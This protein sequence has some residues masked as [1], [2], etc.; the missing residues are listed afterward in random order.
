MTCNIHVLRENKL[1]ELLL[2]LYS[3][4][5][6]GFEKAYKLYCSGFR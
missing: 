3:S 5:L 2:Q 1:F 4:T 6:L